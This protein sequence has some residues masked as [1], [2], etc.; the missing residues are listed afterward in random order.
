[1]LRCQMAPVELHS[2][3]ILG[4][5]LGMVDAQRDRS[6]NLPWRHWSH[7]IYNTHRR[8]IPDPHRIVRLIAGSWIAARL[9][10]PLTNAPMTEPRVSAPFGLPSLGQGNNIRGTMAG[11][12]VSRKV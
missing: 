11:Q 9:N 7:D 4:I 3:I 12:L 5:I 2:R 6:I 10:A 1:M 8:E